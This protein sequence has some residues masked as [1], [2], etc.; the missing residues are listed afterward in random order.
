MNDRHGYTSEIQLNK[1]KAELFMTRILQQCPWI[2]PGY[3]DE[4][5][6]LWTSQRAGFIAA[7]DE[8]RKGVT[9]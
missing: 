7:V 1:K 9:T 6:K 3:T 5:K 8:R 2:V 4:L